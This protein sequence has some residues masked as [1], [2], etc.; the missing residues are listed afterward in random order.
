MHFQPGEL[1]ALI[2][3]VG[4][5]DDI[6]CTDAG[7]SDGILG[8]SGD[9]DVILGANKVTGADGVVDNMADNHNK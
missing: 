8:I 2:E 6:G 7:I 3:L 5:G 4:D 1:D 9:T